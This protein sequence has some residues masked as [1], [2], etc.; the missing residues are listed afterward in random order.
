MTDAVFI[1]KTPPDGMLDVPLMVGPVN[2][3]FDNGANVPNVVAKFVP[4][5]V[6]VGVAIPPLAVSNPVRVEVPVFVRPAVI[7]PP[8]GPPTFIVLLKIDASAKY[9]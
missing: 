4:F 2:T 9:T 1:F 7:R 8:P 5:S 3:G 6:I